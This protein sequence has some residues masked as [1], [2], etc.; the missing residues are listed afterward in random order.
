MSYHKTKAGENSFSWKQMDN[1][2]DKAY[3]AFLYF[4]KL[5]PKRSATG[6]SKS[7]EPYFGT[8]QYISRLIGK[9]HWWD[10]LGSYFSDPD[11]DFT[12][13]ERERQTIGEARQRI[14]DQAN[15][16]YELLHQA[17]T[18]LYDEMMGKISE[19][20]PSELKSLIDA[21]KHLDEFAR[22][23]VKMPTSYGNREQDEPT[24]GPRGLTDDSRLGTNYSE[25]EI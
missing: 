5:G 16:D 7:T 10:R 24:S 3:D 11:K 25:D 12:I 15:K 19:L 6:V 4:L 20:K 21:R 9:F 2:P 22:R 8:S 17:W 14:L 23:S 1:E 13:E 18:Q